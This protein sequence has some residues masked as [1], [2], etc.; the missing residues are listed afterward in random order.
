MLGLL[1]L[2]IEKACANES[3]HLSSDGEKQKNE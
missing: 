3:G 1:L 2:G